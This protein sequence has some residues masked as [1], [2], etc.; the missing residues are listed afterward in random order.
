MR[1]V[2][3][4]IDQ[5]EAA[6]QVDLERAQQR[7]EARKAQH[8]AAATRAQVQAVQRI[9][10]L[11]PGDAAGVGRQLFYAEGRLEGWVAM[12]FSYVLLYSVVANKAT[13]EATFDHVYRQ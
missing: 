9:V 2:Y 13:T 8:E 6:A 5:A 4:P 7:A 12:C 1:S 3:V 10:R 11:E